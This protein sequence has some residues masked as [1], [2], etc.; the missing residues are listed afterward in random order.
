MGFPE[1]TPEDMKSASSKGGSVTSEKKSFA[2]SLRQ[3]KIALCRNCPVQCQFKEAMLKVN[4]E[5]TCKIPYSRATAIKD[6]TNITMMTP[7]VL[8]YHVNDL[9]NFFREEFERE[10]N[11]QMGKILF[12]RYMVFKDKFY[13]AIQKNVNVN[14]HVFNQKLEDWR[15]SRMQ[16]YIGDEVAAEIEVENESQT[17]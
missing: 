17:G 16:M 10:P 13:P 6:N 2:A 1:R 8:E 14:M 5:A 3:S 4:P 7:E 9:L 15:K 11:V 12:D